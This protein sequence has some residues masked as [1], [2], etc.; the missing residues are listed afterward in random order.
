M[1]RNRT[2][3]TLVESIIVMSLLAVV[4][5]IGAPKLSAALRRRITS[6]A[7][8]QF[9]ASHSLAR[10]TAVR[11]GRIAQLHIDPAARRFWIDV[12]TSA[13]AVGERATIWYARDISDAGLTMTSNRTLLCFDAGGLAS[14]AGSCE[15][16]DSQVIFA[17]S[18]KADTVTTTALGK[19]VR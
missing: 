5:A 16:G 6:V 12:D 11:Y 1:K 15:P 8:D 4:A 9:V 10:A 17:K 7:A 13:D 14:T 19:V 2:G 3:F 18:D